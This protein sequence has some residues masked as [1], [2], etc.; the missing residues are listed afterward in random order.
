VDR[1]SWIKPGSSYLPS[2]LN[3]AV[4]D[5]QLDE[6]DTIQSLRHGVWNSYAAGLAQWADDQGVRLMSVPAD[7]EHPAH[8]FFMI[9]PSSSDQAGLIKHLGERDIVAAFH[10]TPLD[11]SAA[12]REF[13]IAPR[14]CTV[15]ADFSSRLVRLPL[16]AGL[17]GEQVSTVIDAVCAYRV[18]R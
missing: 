17:S 16:W 11:S 10:Y 1:Y 2:E 12:G 4:L 15:T 18:D 7:R 8:L 5:S 6:F 9:M 3:A 14:P 13:G